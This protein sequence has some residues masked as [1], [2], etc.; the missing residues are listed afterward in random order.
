[1]VLLPFHD[2][3][4]DNR[5]AVKCSPL[6]L[7]VQKQ[8]AEREEEEEL[9]FLVH[10]YKKKQKTEIIHRWYER[11]LYKSR[12]EDDEFGVLVKSVRSL[13]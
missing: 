6:L 10:I 8:M 3:F 9:L 4:Y 11:P 12:V 13:K 2:A 7:E 5:K 1:M